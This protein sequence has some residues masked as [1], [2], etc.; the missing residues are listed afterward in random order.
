MH[1]VAEKTTFLNVRV[2]CKNNNLMVLLREAISGRADVLILGH[3]GPKKLN[4][5][6][7]F[8]YFAI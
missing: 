8:Y 3:M 7:K 2:E 1:T 4:P 5:I 6:R